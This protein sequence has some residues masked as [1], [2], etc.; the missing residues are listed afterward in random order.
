MKV[1]GGKSVITLDETFFPIEQY[2]S[3]LDNLYARVIVIQ[4]N[5]NIVLVSLE[6]TSLQTYAIDTIKTTVMKLCLV[7]KDHIF[8]SV[9][10][11]FSAPHTRS[12]K[13]LETADKAV[14]DKNQ[15]LLISICQAVTNA[16]QQA[17][18]SAEEASIHLGQGSVA[19]NVNRDIETTEGYWLGQNESGFSS[20]RLPV[21]CFKNHLNRPI[22]IIYSY[23]VQSS[24]IANYNKH[25]VSADLV[26]KASQLIEENTSSAVAIYLL[27]CAADQIPKYQTAN[28]TECVQLAKYLY[29]AVHETS[30]KVIDER[31]L[32]LTTLNLRV[33]GQVLPDMKSLQPQRAYTYL[34]AED[35]SVRIDLL[36]L[37]SLALV[38]LQPELASIT[39]A[40][41]VRQLPH[42]NIIVATMI[43]GSQKYMVNEAAYDIMTYEAMN[44]M[45]AQGSAEV[46]SSA[47]IN[48]L[49]TSE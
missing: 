20:S 40:E 8:I 49:S 37:G 10:H 23:D 47:V 38:M 18:R 16:C 11:T 26:G 7:P 2:E 12:K 4:S 42:K 25:L 30:L 3:V 24:L 19:V 31:K 17:L 43:N 33:A 21:I 41:I 39:G 5:L 35:R 44:S 29:Q 6:M 48:A 34:P 13:A 46:V 9:T 36:Q 22:A 45:F 32:S 15:Q 27:G 28:L 1:G 14:Y